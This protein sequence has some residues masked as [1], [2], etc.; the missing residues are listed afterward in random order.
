MHARVSGRPAS[1]RGRAQGSRAWRGGAQL[2]VADAGHGAVAGV[3]A[4][5][6]E[7][8]DEPAEYVAPLL[9]GYRQALEACTAPGRGW[10]EQRDR[11]WAWMQEM[12]DA[13]GRAHGVGVGSLD[14]RA[15]CSAASMKPTAAT[16]RQ[17]V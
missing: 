10:R 15:E 1:R 12:P 7:L 2:L 17:E 6:V 5:R 13:N 11:H 8:V 4:F 14:V 3:G 16:L 9:E